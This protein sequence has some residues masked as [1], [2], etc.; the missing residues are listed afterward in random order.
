[1]HV[2]RDGNHTPRM[3]QK[4]ENLVDEIYDLNDEYTQ[5]L[6]LEARETQQT[7]Y[8]KIGLWKERRALNVN[9]YSLR[10]EF[11]RLML[12]IKE[13]KTS[14]E[15]LRASMQSQ[16]RH[17][18]KESEDLKQFVKSCSNDDKVN[19]D[20]RERIATNI[21]MYEQDMRP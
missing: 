9:N 20:Q 6:A 3:Q 16:I 13:Q 10:I 2:N 8:K 14:R 4:I 18:C 7:K 21:R 1:M 19:K 17:I 5:K 12:K 15:R 11:D